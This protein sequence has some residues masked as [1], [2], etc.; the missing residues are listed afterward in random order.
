[1]IRKLATTVDVEVAVLAF[2]VVTW[3]DE[4]DVDGIK[5]VPVWK[6]CLEER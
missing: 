2:Q 4:R 3:D 1:M 5:I 6:W